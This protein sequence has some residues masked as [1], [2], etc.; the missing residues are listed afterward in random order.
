MFLSWS[1]LWVL[2]VYYLLRIYQENHARNMM[3]SSWKKK[4]RDTCQISNVF[5]SFES[6][7]NYARM[8]FCHHDP[9][10]CVGFK[11]RR[12][13]PCLNIGIGFPREIERH[14][15]ALVYCSYYSLRTRF[16]ILKQNNKKIAMIILY[17]VPL[18]A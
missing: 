12:T 18:K 13:N 5:F 2:P 6:K 15:S 9:I 7:K 10:C 4:K 17:I 11:Q 3:I 1:V 14:R 8:T 16:S